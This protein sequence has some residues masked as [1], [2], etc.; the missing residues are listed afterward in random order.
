MSRAD[1]FAQS[2]GFVLPIDAGFNRIVVAI[3]GLG[4][5][6]NCGDPNMLLKWLQSFQVKSSQQPL[7][8]LSILDKL[9]FFTDPFL[10]AINLT[11]F[12]AY[13]EESKSFNYAAWV[14]DL[15]NKTLQHVPQAE[16]W[17]EQF[18]KNFQNTLHDWLLENQEAII[19]QPDLLQAQEPYSGPVTHQTVGLFIK[20]YLDQFFGTAFVV[21]DYKKEPQKLKERMVQY[22]EKILGDPESPTREKML[23]EGRARAEKANKSPPTAK[24]K[25]S[26]TSD[27]VEAIASASDSDDSSS[28]R[29]TAANRIV[30]QTLR[31]LTW[32]LLSAERMHQAA[33][34][35]PFVYLGSTLTLNALFSEVGRNSSTVGPDLQLATC[36]VDTL[37]KLVKSVETD[38]QG[39]SDTVS[40]LA[41][42][43]TSRMAVAAKN[44]KNTL[45]QSLQRKA[46]F[47]EGVVQSFNREIPLAEQLPLVLP[48]EQDAISPTQVN[49]AGIIRAFNGIVDLF[50]KI[51]AG[52]DEF[53]ALQSTPTPPRSPPVTLPKPLDL[54]AFV[55]DVQDLPADEKASLLKKAME[56][57]S[58][59]MQFYAIHAH[60][61]QGVP[62]PQAVHPSPNP[63][64][65]HSP[66]SDKPKVVVVI[67]PLGASLGGSEKHGFQPV[68]V[69]HLSSGPQKETQ[70]S[71]SLFAVPAALGGTRVPSAEAGNLQQVHSD[72]ITR[73][74]A[75]PS[76][77]PAP[78]SP[79]QEDM[80]RFS[81]GS[82]NNG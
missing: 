47:V 7:E 23:G 43:E 63:Q 20:H 73:I 77:P 17:F 2:Y 31:F 4:A 69:A 30:D 67:R 29:S 35:N 3:C 55:K 75:Q 78:Y 41:L 57:H 39:R 82:G 58:A 21:F 27:V 81:P 61:V 53:D 56:F 25:K 10:A 62:I 13:W 52:C 74:S 14:D 51:K 54:N 40:S 72:T 59:Q 44:L 28:G 11:E 45:F 66:G 64:Q 76:S 79:F 38:V 32:E 50:T 6:P 70:H 9:S 22:A 37:K 24:K 16:A 12:H 49:L 71:P 15:Y 80:N 36:F 42:A 68:P 26:R 60:Q 33:E 34:Q 65:Q 8:L 1:Q 46:Q 18:K 5:N 19:A 48:V